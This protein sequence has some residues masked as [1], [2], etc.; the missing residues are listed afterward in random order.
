[1][2]W[3]SSIAMRRYSIEPKTTKYVKGYGFLFFVRKYKKQL[4]DTGL[5]SLK[6]ASKKLVHKAGGILGNKIADAV[7]KSNDDKI[8]DAVTKSN[9]DKLL[10][11]EP[12]E[13][14]IIPLEEKR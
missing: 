4:L 6:A 8:A 7:T 9:H 14:I 2:T 11:E 1:M 10:K 12:V 3:S 5:D 13:E